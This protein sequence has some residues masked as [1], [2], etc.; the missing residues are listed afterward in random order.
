M[1][2][3]ERPNSS[4]E[5]SSRRMVARRPSRLVLRFRAAARRPQA[6]MNIG[7]PARRVAARRVKP[8]RSSA[9]ER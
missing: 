8:A 9:K 2:Y 1:K 5:L 3:W 4:L 7:Q 6:V